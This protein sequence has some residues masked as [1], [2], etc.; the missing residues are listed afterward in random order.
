M[1]VRERIILNW[2]KDAAITLQVQLTDEQRII[3]KNA[4]NQ[5][6]NALLKEYPASQA[7]WYIAMKNI[8]FQDASLDPISLLKPKV[9]L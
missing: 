5:A 8:I 3:V 7:T 2:D 4:V 9:D 1:D 6:E